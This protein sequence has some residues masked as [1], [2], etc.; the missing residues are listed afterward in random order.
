MTR[1]DA[2]TGYDA[3]NEMWLRETLSVWIGAES[4]SC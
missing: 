1:I 2:T 3:G 4:A